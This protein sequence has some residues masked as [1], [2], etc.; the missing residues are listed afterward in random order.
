MANQQPD[1]A[2][3]QRE[4]A[5]HQAALSGVS[6]Q[7]SAIE[8]AERREREAREQKARELAILRSKQERCRVLISR[9]DGQIAEAQ[10]TVPRQ[11]ENACSDP[12][13]SLRGL[14]EM[15]LELAAL[16]LMLEAFR[17][18]EASLQARIDAAD[19]EP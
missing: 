7:I 18:C 17:N 4:Q 3:L 12:S 11:A 19:R 10:N 9:L 16:E 14:K 2:A 6:Q 15:L 13:V 1:L 8:D 5:K